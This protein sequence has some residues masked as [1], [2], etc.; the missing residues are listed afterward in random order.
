MKFDHDVKWSIGNSPRADL[1]PAQE[2]GYIPVGIGKDAR[3]YN[4]GLWFPSAED[5]LDF[6][7]GSYH[8]PAFNVADMA[9]CL[10]LGLVFL[11]IF[12]KRDAQNR[13]I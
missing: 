4:S 6:Y 7:L 12:I 11:E 3:N 1:A 10:G 9:I 8:W 13:F 5:F 2:A